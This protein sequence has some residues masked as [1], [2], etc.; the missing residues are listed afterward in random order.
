M[1]ISYHSI[2]YLQHTNW[3]V[4]EGILHLLAH[5]IISQGNLDE[6]NGPSKDSFDPN[7]MAFN[8]H[9]ITEMITLA[10]IEQKLKIQQMVIDCLSLL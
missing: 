5:C 1:T 7:H 4:R 6:L 9:F 2:G 3:H 8:S 10:K